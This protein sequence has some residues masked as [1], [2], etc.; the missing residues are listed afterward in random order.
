[1]PGKGR[2]AARENGFTAVV[3]KAFAGH[4]RTRSGQRSI[5]FQA[6]AFAIMESASC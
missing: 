6:R 5:Q 3:L 2:N 4:N 1:L